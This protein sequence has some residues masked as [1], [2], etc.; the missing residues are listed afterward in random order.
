MSGSLRAHRQRLIEAGL[1]RL[2]VH[3]RPADAQLIRHL[4]RSLARDDREGARLRKAL[5]ALVPDR[6]G[7]SFKEWQASA[8]DSD[9]E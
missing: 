2:E 3:A 8:D 1:R 6:K 5:E 4:A 9:E 7:P